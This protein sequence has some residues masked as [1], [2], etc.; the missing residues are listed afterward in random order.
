MGVD[1]T[2]TV[3]NLITLFGLFVG[4]VVWCV[5]TTLAINAL[6]KSIDIMGEKV[7]AFMMESKGDRLALHERL[8]SLERKG[9]DIARYCEQD[10]GLAR[11]KRRQE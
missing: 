9:C 1:P 4:G 3:G 6:R 2:I 11:T 10:L 8:E 5:T 7:A